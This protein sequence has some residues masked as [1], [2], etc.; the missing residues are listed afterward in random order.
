MEPVDQIIQLVSL[1]DDLRAYD[2]KLFP[3]ARD[4]FLQS[5]LDADSHVSKVYSERGQ[6]KGYATLRPC[7][8]GY[9]IGPLFAD[10]AD[11]ARA[12]IAAVLDTI[13]DDHKEHEV[14]VD[15]PQPNASAFALADEL[16]LEKVF[17]TARMY[18]HHQPDIDLDRIF[19]VTTFELG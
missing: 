5:W 4:L 18:S 8:P 12:L 10:S 1:S 7:Q 16:G 9:K 2:R 11:I 13:P 19:G 3:A 6:I 17:E 14:F 15:M